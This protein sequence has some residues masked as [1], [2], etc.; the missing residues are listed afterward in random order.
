MNNEALLAE[1][2]HEMA[3]TRRVLAAVPDDKLDWKPHDKSFSLGELAN[4]TANIPMWSELTMKA[5]ELQ[6][7]GMDPQPEL[8][9]VPAI[10]SAFDE[11]VAAARAAF[12]EADPAS[13]GT[14]WTAKMGDQVVFSM[15]RASVVRTFIMNHMIHHRGQLTVYLRLLDE[16]VPGVYG[17][18]A[19]DDG[20]MGG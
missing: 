10:V 18:S 9:A 3:S 15:P 19:D 8:D 14:T 1:F 11:R 12:A 16:P 13:W 6:F 4:H 5:E 2:D 20:G 17:P 7:E